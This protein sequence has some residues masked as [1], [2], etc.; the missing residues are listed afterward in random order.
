MTEMQVK[1]CS[2]KCEHL[3][4]EYGICMR[5][6]LNG[7]AKLLSRAGDAFISD[8]SHSCKRKKSKENNPLIC[9]KSCAFLNADYGICMRPELKNKA[10]V[11]NK[12]KDGFIKECNIFQEFDKKDKRKKNNKY[13]AKKVVVDG[14]TYDSLLEYSRGCELK[15]LEKAGVIS[16]LQHHVPFVL[17]EKSE[18]GREIKYEADF[19]YKQN[20][21]L[22]VEDD[23]SAPTKTRL[24]KLKKRLMLEKY[25]IKIKEFE[26]GELK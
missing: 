18:N 6:E 4:K 10:S 11:L 8:C 22:I 13:N 16:E 23:K 20:G 1:F 2:P 21:E 26:K 15:L 7:R 3:H 5:P 19:V 17:I 14:E 12:N 25:G 24:Y 9:P